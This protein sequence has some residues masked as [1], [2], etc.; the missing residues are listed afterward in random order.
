MSNRKLEIGKGLRA[1]ISDIDNIDI[2][3]KTE[4]VKQLASTIAEISLKQIEVNPNQPRKDFDDTALAELSASISEHGLIQPITVRSLGGDKFQVISGER[5]YRASKM[6]GLESVPA[7]VR[8]AD[9][10]AM[11][12]MALIENIQ[13]EDLN[14]LEVAMGYQRLIDE[15]ALT[16]D[17][18]SKRLGKNRASVTNHLRLLK[19][20]PSIKNGLRNG[21]ISMGH[22]R[23]IA[24][25]PVVDQQLSIYE[26]AVSRKLSV[27]QVE[28]L[29]KSLSQTKKPSKNTTQ[30]LSA[31]WK[32]V[33]NG[34]SDLLGTTVAIDLNKN[35]SGQ[36]SISFSDVE[37]FNS[38]MEIIQD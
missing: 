7:Y 37:H 32:E 16:H 33:Q 6:A 9:D 20:P 21:L 26:Q 36:M 1:L 38:I 25:A 12:E 24:G 5:R 30:E 22:A 3:Q 17:E 10:Q 34:L 2:D 8:I 15:C 18:L 28:A 35:G 23:A 13:R 4:N 31:D 29:V 19:L 27:R 11:L 14:A